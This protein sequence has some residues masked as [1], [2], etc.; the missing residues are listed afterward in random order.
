M[1]LMICCFV[2]LTIEVSRFSETPVDIPSTIWRY[3]LV[4]KKE[5]FVTT[6]V[7]R[8][9]QFVIPSSGERTVKISLPCYCYSFEDIYVTMF[10]AEHTDSQYLKI[11]ELICNLL[12]TRYETRN[13]LVL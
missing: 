1:G 2:Y 12:Y 13:S 6:A 8:N 3:I 7:V 5:L 10:S 11:L 9:S 4:E